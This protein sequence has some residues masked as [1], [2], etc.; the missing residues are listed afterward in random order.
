MDRRRQT[1][2]RTAA[3]VCGLL[4]AGALAGQADPGRCLTVRDLQR[5]DGCQLRALFMA[6]DV[7]NPPV[8][9]IRGKLIRL[10][11]RRGVVRTALTNAV[12]KGKSA[13]A[14]GSFVNRWVGGVEGIGS[15]Y[16]VGPS[17][18]DGNPA[19]VIE[20][21]PGTPLF[22][23]TR[24][25]LREVAPGLYLGPLYDRCPVPTL[26]GWLALEAKPCRERFLAA[27]SADG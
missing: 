12:W 13:A 2:I 22:A 1:L 10:A 24:D 21:P 3:G 27:P 4:V 7:G 8:G 18:V 25:E 23:N 6:S 16:V 19:V 17:W 11:D 5:M 9:T 26:R 15:R 14:D 20:Y